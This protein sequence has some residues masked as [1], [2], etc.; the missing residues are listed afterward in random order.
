MAE[1]MLSGCIVATVQ[2]D[3]EHSELSKLTLPLP[4]TSDAVPDAQIEAA[5]RQL[6]DA[7]LSRMALQS[8][9]YARR[10]LIGTAML[11]NVVNVLGRF[12]RGARGYIVS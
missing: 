11:A 9:V 4:K 1:A 7:D 2:P 12:N 8:F 10:N 5:L 6:T 3:V